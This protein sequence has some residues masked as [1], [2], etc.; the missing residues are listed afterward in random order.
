MEITIEEKKL[1]EMIKK[2][3]SEVISD[4][5]EK[6]KMELIPYASNKEM[7]EIKEIFGFPKKYKNQQFIEQKL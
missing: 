2:A 3:V 6:L 4:N 5:F 1:Y 7:D